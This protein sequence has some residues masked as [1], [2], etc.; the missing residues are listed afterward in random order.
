MNRNRSE[1]AEKH[2]DQAHTSWEANDLESAL[3]ESELAIQLAPD[4]AEAHNLRGAILEELGCPGRWHV[5]KPIPR[6]SDRT[7]KMTWL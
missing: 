1:E 7:A 6:Y 4:L 2:L 3:R 5:G